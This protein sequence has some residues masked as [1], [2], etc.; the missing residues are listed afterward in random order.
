MPIKILSPCE[1]RPREAS[2]SAGGR[3]FFPTKEV[4]FFL[5]RCAVPRHSVFTNWVDGFGLGM[6]NTADLRGS[7]TCRL[8]LHNTTANTFASNSIA[9]GEPAMCRP[10]ARSFEVLEN[11][12][13]LA[14]TPVGTEGKVGS[15]LVRSGDD[16]DIVSFTKSGTKGASTNFR[17][18]MATTE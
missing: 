2:Y 9:I 15:L 8:S 16:I 11:R 6:S 14:A 17:S 4:V 3:C 12:V 1:I 13:C 10:R 18:A 5:R 7:T